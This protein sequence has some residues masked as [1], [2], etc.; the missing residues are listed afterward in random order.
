MCASVSRVSLTRMIERN[1]LLVR[2]ARAALEN[3]V[4]SSKPDDLVRLYD[5]LLQNATDL[6]EI[7]ALKDD[8]AFHKKIAAQSL[9]FKALR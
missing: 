4:S 5:S 7:D 6:A 1:T 2:V 8:I 3:S 9:Y